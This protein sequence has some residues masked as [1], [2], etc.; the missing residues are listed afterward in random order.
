L[1]PVPK[2]TLKVPAKST[3]EQFVIAKLGQMDGSYADARV[4]VQ[5]SFSASRG[6]SDGGMHTNL[7]GSGGSC[8][9]GSDEDGG[10]WIDGD[11]TGSGGGEP[12]GTDPAGEPPAGG[13]GSGGA[14][15]PGSA[16]YIARLNAYYACL[17]GCDTETDLYV[18]ACW[19]A[20]VQDP[21]YLPQYPAC[22][23][24]A[25]A[26]NTVCRARCVF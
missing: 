1:P 19:L 13:G 20:A 11:C 14:P 22:E 6:V 15:D 18:Q 17:Q 24:W 16:E 12:G 8:T 4:R 21:K 3:V 7:S 26:Q 9:G 2:Y 5:A 10:E 25:R 23:A